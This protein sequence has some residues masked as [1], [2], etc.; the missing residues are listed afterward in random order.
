M[1]SQWWGSGLSRWD[2]EPRGT[3]R[4]E[5][6][7]PAK[8]DKEKADRFKNVAYLGCGKHALPLEDRKSLLV[9]VVSTLSPRDKPALSKIAV[10][11]FT[12]MTTHSLL[13]LLSQTTP[14]SH[15]RLLRDDEGVFTIEH[16]AEMLA[17]TAMSL[18]P[19]QALA[20]PRWVR[21]APGFRFG[22]LWF[23]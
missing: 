20:D 19:Q 11:A 13:Y 5:F 15:I 6:E 23:R 14:K 4:Q 7:S 12:A 18:Y 2:D 21:G 17:E 9:A 16:A 3:W 1:S 22:A 8:K 10:S